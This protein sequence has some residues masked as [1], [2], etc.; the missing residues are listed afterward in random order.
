MTNMA[1]GCSATPSGKSRN[2]SFCAKHAP[3]CGRFLLQN[4][5]LLPRFF[6]ILK[7]TKARGAERRLWTCTASSSASQG[8]GSR[9]TTLTRRLKER[10]GQDV[11][12][13]SHD[14]Y[15][16]RHDELPYEE[17]CKL[18]YDHPD[19]LRH[20]P[21]GGADRRLAP[22]R[23]SSRARLRFHGNRSSETLLIAPTSVIVLEG[24]LIF[25][26]EKLRSLDGR[27]NF[28]RHRRRCAHSAACGGET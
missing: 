18:N 20:R 6:A 28:C 14:N 26:D 11:S 2:R 16:K 13:I 8:H 10:F 24:I 25:A 17:R 23:N 4:G 3:L 9:K 12:V 15:Y 1:A 21:D 5:F 22:Q 27:E 19:A 7:K